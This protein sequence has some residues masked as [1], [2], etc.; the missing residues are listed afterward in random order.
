MYMNVKNKE[1]TKLLI[2]LVLFLIKNVVFFSRDTNY[3]LPL[4]FVFTVN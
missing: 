3:R 4:N 1:T 2:D